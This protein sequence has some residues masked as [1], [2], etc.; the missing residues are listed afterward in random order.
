[1]GALAGD[2][3]ARLEYPRTRAAELLGISRR[4]LFDKVRAYGLDG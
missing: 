4:Q 3:G 1:M 2:R